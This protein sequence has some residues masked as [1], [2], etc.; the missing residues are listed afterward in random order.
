MTTSKGVEP[1]TAY[2]SAWGGNAARF[3]HNDVLTDEHPKSHRGN[4]LVVEDNALPVK[5]WQDEDVRAKVLSWGVTLITPPAEDEVRESKST[6]MM[7][8][9]PVIFHVPSDEKKEE[10]TKQMNLFNREQGVY[11]DFAV[12]KDYGSSHV[13]TDGDYNVGFVSKPVRQEVTEGPTPS[14]TSRL[15]E[16]GMLAPVKWWEDAQVQANFKEWGV[17][18]VTPPAD[19][20]VRESTSTGMMKYGPVVL[21][22]TSEGVQKE[23]M[24]QMTMFNR[25]TGVYQKFD[26][27]IGQ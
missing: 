15:V 1:S 21:H 9:G 17:T 13:P 20:D 2:N 4:S 26:V 18:K 8:Y 6:G 14:T 27:V 12:V 10:V 7:K 11:W 25:S 3:G 22:V 23:V 16:D 19:D 5:W 24:K